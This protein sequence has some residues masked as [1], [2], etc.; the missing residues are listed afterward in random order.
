MGLIAR[1]TLADCEVAHELQKKEK[2]ESVTWRPHWV[3]CLTLLRAVGHVLEN[4]D[5]ETDAKHRAAIKQRWEEWK[6]NKDENSIF[7]NFIEVERN[8]LL[9]EY[10]FGV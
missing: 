10:K 6:A 1:A 2:K 4:A 8:N 5:G 7:W 3:L 9:K